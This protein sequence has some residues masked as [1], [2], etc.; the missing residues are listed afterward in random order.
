MKYLKCIFAGF[1]TLAL[2][3]VFLVVAGHIIGWHVLF[4]SNSGHLIHH[5]RML[6]RPNSKI[7]VISAGGFRGGVFA[8]CELGIVALVIYALGVDWEVRCL[9]ESVPRDKP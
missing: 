9:S 8:P 2:I 7:I 3:T 5:W 4:V 6:L 1:I